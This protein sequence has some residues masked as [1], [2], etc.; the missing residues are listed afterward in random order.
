M[1]TAAQRKANIRTALGLVALAA[2]FL[3]GFVVK[4]VWLNA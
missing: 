4:I 2:M 1:P 3:A